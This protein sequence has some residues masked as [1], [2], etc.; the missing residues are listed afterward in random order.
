MIVLET[1]RDS[2]MYILVQ[3][4]VSI[5]NSV[6]CIGWRFGPANYGMQRQWWYILWSP[7]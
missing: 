5:Q 4:C 6:G 7:D 3:C 2:W 1:N